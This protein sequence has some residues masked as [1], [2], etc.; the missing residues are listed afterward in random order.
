[1]SKQMKTMVKQTK[2]LGGIEEVLEDIGDKDCYD[3][4]SESSKPREVTKTDYQKDNGV[5]VAELKCMVTGIS[6][7]TPIK[8]AP[9]SPTPKNPVNLSHLPWV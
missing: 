4:I 2:V 5:I 7:H 1:M 3:R 9:T 8:A 6:H